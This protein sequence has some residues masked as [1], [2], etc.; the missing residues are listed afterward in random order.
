[1]S[2]PS[3]N[4]NSDRHTYDC[5]ISLD[6]IVTRYPQSAEMGRVL[7]N[8]GFPADKNKIIQF[9]QKQQES[10]KECRLDSKEILPLLNEI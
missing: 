5:K 9:V 4:S 7:M 3:S 2:S 8:M 10:S 1:M 6:E